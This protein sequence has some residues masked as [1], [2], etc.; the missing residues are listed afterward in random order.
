MAVS[1]TSSDLHVS[2]SLYIPRAS[3]DNRM[4][5]SPLTTLMLSWPRE[6]VLSPL[7]ESIICVICDREGGGER[8]RRE[9]ERQRKQF[10]STE[11]YICL[12]SGF[13]F[14]SD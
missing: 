8:E 7:T 13:A 5:R 3:I 10:F 14:D 4:K 6:K 12:F 2:V 11:Y 1:D 9:R